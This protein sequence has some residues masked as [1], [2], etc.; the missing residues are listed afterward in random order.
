ML[1]SS[2]HIFIHSILNTP[3]ICSLIC[4]MFRVSLYL[5]HTRQIFSFLWGRGSHTKFSLIVSENESAFPFDTSK[6]GFVQ[7]GYKLILCPAEKNIKSPLKSA[8]ELPVSSNEFYE[9]WEN[10]FLCWL[11]CV[12]FVLKH[13]PLACPSLY[14]FFLFFIFNNMAALSVHWSEDDENWAIPSVWEARWGGQWI[15]YPTTE[16]MKS[17][18]F[19]F[20]DKHSERQVPFVVPSKQFATSDHWYHGQD[21]LKRSPN[22]SL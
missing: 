5:I 17:L 10:H 19:I 21:I 22:P 2:L 7:Q 3:N 9:G 15:Q 11:L 16:P 13:H 18:I 6:C 20:P 1:T 4:Q 8:W 12:C 14:V